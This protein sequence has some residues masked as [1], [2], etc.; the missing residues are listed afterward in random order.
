MSSPQ[1]KELGMGCAASIEVNTSLALVLRGWCWMNTSCIVD[2]VCY[3]VCL[4][5]ANGRNQKC[6]LKIQPKYFWET[7]YQDR[8][9]GAW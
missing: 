9:Y 4:V 3:T 2:A 6:N 7:L 8:Y 1:R 5:L